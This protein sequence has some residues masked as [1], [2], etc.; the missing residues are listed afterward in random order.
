MDF[1]KL[2]RIANLNFSAFTKW[3]TKLP[4]LEIG[5]SF[6]LRRKT[7]DK[8]LKKKKIFSLSPMSNNFV[9]QKRKI[10]TATPRFVRKTKKTP[11]PN[12]KFPSIYK[13]ACSYLKFVPTFVDEWHSEIS[14]SYQQKRRWTD[15][16]TTCRRTDWTGFVR[17]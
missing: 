9:N 8:K 5:V 14:T 17:Q 1:Q 6:K 2:K 11:F 7:K 3:I 12:T 13:R 16:W 15:D 10:F 4:A